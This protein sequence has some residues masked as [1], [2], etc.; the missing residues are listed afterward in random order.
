MK[1]FFENWRQYLEEIDFDF[2]TFELKK[3]LNPKIWDGE[4]LRPEVASRLHDIVND[5]WS[6]LDLKDAGIVD[7]IITGSAANYNWSEKS[8]I[9]LHILVNFNDINAPMDL[10]K[11]YFRSVRANWN[12]VHNI[13]IGPHEAEL[14]VQDTGEPHMSTGIYSLVYNEWQTKP[15][16]RE[17]TIDEPLVGKKAQALM[18]LIEDV[19]DVFAAG[20]YEEAR[21]EAIRLRDRIRD[22]RKCGLEQGGEFSPENLAFKVLR[23]NGY[24]GRLSD[25]RTNA[26][27]RMMSLNGGQPSGI[28]IKIGDTTLQEKWSEKERSKRK[29]KCANPKGFTM[30]QFCKNQKTRSK[31]GERTNEKKNPR[32]PRKK[33]QP[34][35][36][37]KHSDLYTDEDP[38]GTIHGLKFATA[39][40]AEASVNKIKRSGRS[41]AH[42]LRA[43][44]A[45]EQRAKAAGKKS[46]AGVYRKYINSVKKTNKK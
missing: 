3:E 40:D 9:D 23:R 27:D 7:I 24:L 2:S 1:L 35:K 30:K 4:K 28:K 17:V 29:N 21:E 20:R 26:Y 13:K 38:K 12:K 36:S 22:F 8:D 11:D 34:A 44:V 14:Y 39:K 25:V 43:A 41:H 10:V 16:Y 31:K 6:G 42:K 18:D 37:K 45:M 19:E 5:F 46:A 32:I 33:G 15:T